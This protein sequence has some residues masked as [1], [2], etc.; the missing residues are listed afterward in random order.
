MAAK[1]AID[2]QP[3]PPARQPVGR[4]KVSGRRDD[5][6]DTANVIVHPYGSTKTA[7]GDNDYDLAKVNVVSPKPKD[8]MKSS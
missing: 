3:Q 5:N 6:E 8:E 1:R 2:L 4:G 7:T